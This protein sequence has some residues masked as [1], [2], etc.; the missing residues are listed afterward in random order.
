MNFLSGLKTIYKHLSQVDLF[1][2]AIF[3]PIVLFIYHVFGNIFDL[4]RSDI[5]DLEYSTYPLIFVSLIVYYLVYFVVNKKNVML[6]S[7]KIPWFSKLFLAGITALTVV[8]FFSLGYLIFTGQ[9]GILDESIRRNIDPKLNFL[10]SFFWFG[11]LILITEY[12][13]KKQLNMKKSLLILGTSTLF[14]LAFYVLIGYRTNLFMIVFTLV[15]FFHYFYKRFNF[16]LVILFLIALS[17]TFSVFGHMRVQNEDK[18]LEF[19]KDPVENVVIDK[20]TK[21]EI[22]KVYQMPEWAR[23]ITAEF[24]SG[25]IVLSRIIQ[26]TNEEGSLKGELHAS[27]FKTL[28]P[29]TNLSPRT[30]VTEKVNQFSD[31]GIP[32]TREGRTTTPS[33]LGQL[34]LDGGYALLIFG[35]G[36]ISLLLGS[37]Y[38]KIKAT[39]H[40]NYK[41]A[42]SF[43]TTLFVICIHTGLLDIV[44]FIFLIGMILYSTIEKKKI[45]KI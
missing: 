16:K 15:L 36:L 8:G 45:E 40:S 35:I 1:S 28:L 9:I 22:A 43:I 32:V 31:N 17:I 18:T 12:L 30:I 37:I 23:I 19:N 13:S 2:P 26:Y 33:L 7:I 5:F 41:I 39:G 3:F 10:S 24:V 6:P 11:F 25:K 42:Y 20:E 29:G 14:V 38:N 44:F 4:H 27:A 34:F 21:K